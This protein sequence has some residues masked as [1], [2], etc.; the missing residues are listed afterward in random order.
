MDSETR[1]TLM[2]LAWLFMQSGRM[3]KAQVWAAA[4]AA[5]D[6][7]DGVTAALYGRLLLE[8]AR[9]EEALA[10]LQKG[11]FSGKIRRVGALLQARALNDLGRKEE[12]VATWRAFLQLDS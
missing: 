10:V 11:K 9:P 3:D 2:M 12:A 6:P 5:D 4:L 7:T 1:Q 8:D